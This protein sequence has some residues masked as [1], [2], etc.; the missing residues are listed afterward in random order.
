METLRFKKDDYQFIKE[1]YPQLYKLY[2]NPYEKNGIV[3]VPLPS[4]DVYDKYIDA[5][6]D[7]IADS[8]DENHDELSEDG[9]RLE[10]A[11]NYADWSED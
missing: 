7:C 4:Y 5:T 1:K 8:L 6:V 9:L 10:S 11:W 2:K 3:Y